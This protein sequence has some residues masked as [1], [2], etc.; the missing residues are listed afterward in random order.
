MDGVSGGAEGEAADAHALGASVFRRELGIDT[1]AYLANLL[2]SFAAGEPS[3]C[4]FLCV[5]A[6]RKNMNTALPGRHD[7]FE[8]TV[9]RCT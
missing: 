3:H 8:S 7:K 4:V 1:R 6:V 2:P 9:V 5:E